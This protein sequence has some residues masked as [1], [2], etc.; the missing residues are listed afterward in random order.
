LDNGGSPGL[1]FLMFRLTFFS[2]ASISKLICLIYKM[3]IANN[4]KR[5]CFSILN[6]VC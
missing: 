1:I 2:F 6:M 4:A 5:N 3:L